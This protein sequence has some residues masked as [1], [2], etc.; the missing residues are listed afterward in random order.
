MCYLLDI[1]PTLG[2]LA[3]VPAP[4]GSEGLSLAPVLRGERRSVREAIFTAYGKVQRAVRD[5]RW[6]LIVYPAIG[7]TQLF[8]LESDPAE[9]HDL[10]G[11]HAFRDEVDR[12]SRLLA[13]QQQAFGDTL[14]LSREH[15]VLP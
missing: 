4:S 1:F 5:D 10:A 8:D 7:R 2:E 11:D 14:R 13:S 15:P 3:G 12:M 9:L 6:K